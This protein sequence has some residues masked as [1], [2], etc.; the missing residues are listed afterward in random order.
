MP[1][2]GC[3][4]T[5]RPFG[6]CGR[7]L[8]RPTRCI[9][10]CVP[11]L[12]RLR[13]NRRENSPRVVVPVLSAAETANS[14]AARGFKKR[15]PAARR[16]LGAGVLM[17]LA[18]RFR[19]AIRIGGVDLPDEFT[20]VHGSCSGKGMDYI[21]TCHFPRDSLPSG[22]LKTIVPIEA[23]CDQA[24]GPANISDARSVESKLAGCAR[25]DSLS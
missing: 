11:I 4:P 1:A 21:A 5:C 13:I 23:R 22:R 15:R 25:R 8:P 9:W 20:I 17:I 19:I 24:E 16:S 14:G 3:L 12:W 2:F 7:K 6:R 18:D 10:W